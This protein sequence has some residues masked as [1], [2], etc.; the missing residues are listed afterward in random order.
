[1]SNNLQVKGGMSFWNVLQLVLIVLK[2]L[3]LIDW[4]WWLV[5]FP[6]WIEFGIIGVFLL[7]YFIVAVIAAIIDEFDE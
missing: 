1:M 4:S 7:L 6:L 3:G 5:F 2:A